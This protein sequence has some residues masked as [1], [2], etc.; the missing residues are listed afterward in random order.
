MA[1]KEKIVE[2]FPLPL[3]QGWTWRAALDHPICADE[4]NLKLWSHWIDLG[5]GTHNGS[6]KII[7]G[8]K[9]AGRRQHLIP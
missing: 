5:R 3:S 9:G 2:L 8:K 4:N 6:A 7:Y 1:R